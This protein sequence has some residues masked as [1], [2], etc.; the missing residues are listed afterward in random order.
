MTGKFDNKLFAN[1]L[2]TLM[3]GDGARPK[4]TQQELADNIGITR[5]SI[6][7]YKEGHNLQAIEKLYYMSKYFNVPSDYLL[8]LTDM[9]MYNWDLIEKG[10]SEMEDMKRQNIENGNKIAEILSL[11]NET[12]NFIDDVLEKVKRENCHE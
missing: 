8:G 10:V 11:I 7:E 3:S 2:K 4:I 6:S 1:R 9:S 5:Q 12:N